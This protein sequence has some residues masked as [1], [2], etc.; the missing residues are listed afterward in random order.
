MI[1]DVAYEFWRYGSIINYSRI[2]LWILE[3][4]DLWDNFMATYAKIL[5]DSSSNQILP[6]TRAKLVYME[7]NTT[8]E[9]AIN[10]KATYTTFGRVTVGSNMSVNNGILSVSSDNVI[11]ALGYTPV[12]STKVTSK[13]SLGLVIIGTGLK[14]ED[15]GTVFMDASCVSSALGY[16]PANEVTAKYLYHCNLPVSSWGSASSYTDYKTYTYMQTVTFTA[17]NGGPT[18]LN[19][20]K[21]SAPMSIK[22]GNATTNATLQANLN[23]IAAGI[24]VCNSTTASEI[25]VFV[26]EKPSSDITIY[27]EAQS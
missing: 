11:S 15:N 3:N 13:S 25:M 20:K 18:I 12:K 26:K 7:D 21:L 14:V 5:T 9:N 27:F 16:T 8:A 24:M 4:L 6:Y 23:I 22:T 2:L 19:N 17:D 10:Q 1:Y